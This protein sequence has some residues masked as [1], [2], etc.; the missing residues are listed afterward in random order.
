MR[1]F[2]LFAFLP[3]I[4]CADG[5]P[6]GRANADFTPAFVGQTR[7]EALPETGVTITRFATGLTRPWGIAPLPD[8]AWLVTERFGQMRVIDATGAISAPIAG[9]PAV[10]DSGQG[11]LLDV[12]VSPDFAR[13]RQ[14]FWTYAKPVAGGSVTAAA[15]GVLDDDLALRDVRDIWLQNRASRSD[16]HFGS[17]II[18]MADG[19]VW[20]TTCE[21]STR[22]ERQLAQD[23]DVTYGK[24]IRITRDG[25]PVAGNPFLG[26]AGDDTIWSLGH[27]NVQGAAIAPDGVLWTIEHGPRGGDELNMPQAGGNYG[28]PVISYGINYNGSA[29]GDGIAQQDGLVQPVYYWDPVIAPAGMTFY[30][31]PYAPWQG[32]LLIGSLNPGGLVRLKISQGRV[33]GEERLLPD[34]GR[35][36][37]VQMTP[38]GDVLL[39]FDHGDILKLTPG[40]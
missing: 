10:D 29:I 30:D 27:R 32:D 5:V 38:E 6:Q 23:P 7:A 28:W 13:D 8:A 39:V 3:A 12:A 24:I 37:D 22:Q 17:R 16:K 20:I 33:I 35:V 26:Q 18:P 21:R 14:V 19:T 11:G 15:R 4:T 9:L 40:G 34:E 2:V 31:G 36:R 1:A 25:A